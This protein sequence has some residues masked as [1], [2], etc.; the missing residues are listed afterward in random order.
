MVDWTGDESDEFH[1]RFTCNFVLTHNRS[2][3]PFYPYPNTSILGGVSF[4]VDVFGHQ[5]IALV[6]L[7]SCTGS[8][9]EAVDLFCPCQ[10]LNGMEDDNDGVRR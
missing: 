9:K 2:V 6:F 10:S 8:R 1:P 5:Q 7:L 3:M 4:Y